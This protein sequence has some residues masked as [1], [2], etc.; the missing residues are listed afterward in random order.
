MGRRPW[1]ICAA[2]RCRAVTQF[3]WLSFVLAAAILLQPSHAMAQSDALPPIGPSSESESVVESA[4]TSNELDRSAALEQ[5]PIGPRTSTVDPAGAVAEP[6]TPGPSIGRTL[7]ALGVVIALIFA[8]RWV[9]RRASQG[10]GGVSSQLGAG[11]RA[12]SG[13]LSVLGRYPV[14]R[15][16]TLVLMQLDQRILLLSQT[17]SG[18]QTLAEITDPEEVAS[19]LVKSRDEESESLAR[20]FT[21]LLK[22]FERDPSMVDQHNWPSRNPTSVQAAMRLFPETSD[23]NSDN[24]DDP[25]AA[26]RKRIAD[27]EGVVA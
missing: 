4:A 5:S 10:V 17:S 6:P 3:H 1:Q 23:A 7:G 25:L 13:V 14:G 9:M 19:L 21:G 27:L 2:A 20:R 18:F 22:R 24:S 11:G 26:V 12:P 8:T 15:G 16:Q